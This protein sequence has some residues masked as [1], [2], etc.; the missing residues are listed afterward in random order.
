MLIKFRFLRNCGS[1]T[2]WDVERYFEYKRNALVGLPVDLQ[3]MVSDLRYSLEAEGTFWHAE[4]CSISIAGAKVEISFKSNSGRFTYELI[5]RGVRKVAND[6]SIAKSMPTLVIQELI[7]L[8][9]GLY[10]H[11]LADLKGRRV[12][13]YAE[14]IEFFER[15]IQ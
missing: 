11:V 5:Y 7:L 10:R 14:E 1:P 15:S 9:N 6:F 3:S 4:I 2:R 12:A 13:I 8:R